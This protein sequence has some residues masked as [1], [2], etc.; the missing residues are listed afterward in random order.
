[1]RSGTVRPLKRQ[2]DQAISLTNILEFEIII[3]M[4]SDS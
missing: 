4:H 2:Y 3:K 1:M